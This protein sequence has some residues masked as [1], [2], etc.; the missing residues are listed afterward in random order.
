MA[1]READRRNGLPV[2][3][4]GSFVF[5]YFIVGSLLSFVRETAASTLFEIITDYYRLVNTFL[6]ICQP[7]QLVD[8]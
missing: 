7:F 6:N 8:F 1:P 5:D 2:H 4:F 3:L